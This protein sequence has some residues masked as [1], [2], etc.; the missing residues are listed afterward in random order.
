M[1][2]IGII[3]QGP[4]V[5]SPRNYSPSLFM[6]HPFL[7]RFD[8]H[9]V[10]L[11]FHLDIVQLAFFTWYMY[12]PFCH[13]LYIFSVLPPSSRIYYVVFDKH[14][15]WGILGWWSHVL[16]SSCS[17]I[18]VTFSL[19]IIGRWSNILQSLQHGRSW[20]MMRYLLS[21]QRYSL[22]IIGRW[23]N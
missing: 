7:F 14:Y 1:R 23:G 9:A 19:G 2:V 18:N 12:L 16:L 5:N 22:S 4:I 15:S 17:L 10:V 21:Y 11:S 20:T 3:I 13:Q 6:Q 8:G